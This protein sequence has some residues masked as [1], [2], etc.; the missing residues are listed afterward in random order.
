MKRIIILVAIVLLGSHFQERSLDRAGSRCASIHRRSFIG[1]K[2]LSAA[3]DSDSE[4]LLGAVGGYCQQCEL[5]KNKGLCTHSSNRVPVILV[6]GE[7]ENEGEGEDEQG[8]ETLTGPSRTPGDEP[9]QVEI[10][11]VQE[12]G[13]LACVIKMADIERFDGEIELVLKDLVKIHVAIKSEFT[14][15]ENKLAVRSLCEK[16]REGILYLTKIINDIVKEHRKNKN[17]LINMK[18]RNPSFLRSVRAFNIRRQ[19]KDLATKISMLKIRLKNLKISFSRYCMSEVEGLKLLMKQTT[20]GKFKTY[21]EY[22]DTIR[23]IYNTSYLP[24]LQGRHSCPFT[25]D[26]GACTKNDPCERCKILRSKYASGEFVKE[27]QK[28]SKIERKYNNLS[29]RPGE[30]SS[31]WEAYGNLEKRLKELNSSSSSEAEDSKQDLDHGSSQKAAGKPRSKHAVPKVSIISAHDLNGIFKG[32]AQSKIYQKTLKEEEKKY[33]VAKQSK[34]NI[35]KAFNNLATKR[36]VKARDKAKTKDGESGE[37]QSQ[38][39]SNIEQKIPENDSDSDTQTSQDDKNSTEADIDVPSPTK[40]EEDPSAEKTPNLTDSDDNFSEEEILM[41]DDQQASSGKPISKLDPITAQMYSRMQERKKKRENR[42]EERRAAHLNNERR[43]KVRF[44]SELG[45]FTL[46]DPNQNG[47]PKRR[48]PHRLYSG[49]L[50]SKSERPPLTKKKLDILLERRKSATNRAN[51]LG[52]SEKDNTDQTKDKEVGAFGGDQQP[53]HQLDPTKRGPLTKKQLQDLIDR[54]HSRN[55][56]NQTFDAVVIDEDGEH[57]K[58]NTPQSSYYSPSSSSYF[59][60]TFSSTSPSSVSPSPSKP[61]GRPPLTKKKLQTLLARGKPNGPQKPEAETTSKREDE[62]N[63]DA[64]QPGSSSTHPRS[65]L[66][67]RNPLTKRPSHFNMSQFG[68]PK[69]EDE[70]SETEAQA[71]VENEEDE[72]SITPSSSS[73]SPYPQ[74]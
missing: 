74:S 47:Y 25:S 18:L 19:N 11:E 67:R 41:V 66:T 33:R 52:Y 65:K 45:I 39:L 44:D 15:D 13:G 42:E 49:T 68:D 48:Y 50:D 58:S 70:P 22:R 69:D 21:K 34:L 32:G 62:E 4:E 53:R 64:V 46:E 29:R 10:E 38:P 51:E 63:G 40:E 35:L 6:S 61:T 36:N 14:N 30:Y 1:L 59:S 43:K 27:L 26:A 7:S 31:E 16:L 24:F 28:V 9:G 55:M 37:S 57:E 23:N 8:R 71:E 72:K 5:E 20:I 56:N 73:S 2:L 12:S 17:I 60:F 3:K 54:R